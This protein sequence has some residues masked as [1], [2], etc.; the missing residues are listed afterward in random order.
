[1]DNS[2]CRTC[3][4]YT[5]LTRNRQACIDCTQLHEGCLDCNYN[6]TTMQPSTCKECVFGLQVSQ[7]GISCHQQNCDEILVI[8][9]DERAVCTQC[10]DGFGYVERNNTC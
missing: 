5:V 6:A 9:N 1:M 10:S 7:D 3:S 4:P 8:E 2:K